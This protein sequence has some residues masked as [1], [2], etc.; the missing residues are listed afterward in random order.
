MHEQQFGSRIRQVL[1]LG[2]R[3]DASV[4]ERLRAS[5]EQALHAKRPE[6]V[7]ALAWAGATDSSWPVFG[8]W[9]F[10]LVVPTLVLLFG[11]LTIYTWQQDH[12]VAQL[13][14]I[15][16]QLLSDDLPIDAYLDKGFEAWLVERA[17]E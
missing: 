3:L 12:Q 14:E 17:S 16:S 15:D 13:V 10:R 8:G 1:N 6:R 4:G 2:I 7:R 5:R 9:S 11:L